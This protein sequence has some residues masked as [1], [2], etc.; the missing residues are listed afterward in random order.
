MF[1][2]SR[3]SFSRHFKSFSSFVLRIAFGT[4]SI[5]TGNP[6]YTFCSSSQLCFKPYGMH[7]N[8]YGNG[9][10]SVFKLTPSS[11]ARSSCVT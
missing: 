9:A 7:M 2:I 4:V 5:R 6:W 1:S 8:T 10:S 3:M 11:S